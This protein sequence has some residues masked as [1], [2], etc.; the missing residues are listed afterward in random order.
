M[1]L[2]PGVVSVTIE[3]SPYAIVSVG[4]QT[5]RTQTASRGGTNPVWNETFQFNICNENDLLVELKDSEVGRDPNLGSASIN[6]MRV[7]QF[8]QDRQQVPV[9]SQR[10]MEQY[11]LISVSLSFQPD[12]YGSQQPMYGGGMQQP[13]YGGGMQQPMY[14]GGMQQ[15]MYGGG[16]GGMGMGMQGGIGMQQQVMVAE[17]FGGLPRHHHHHHH[18]RGDVEVVVIEREQYY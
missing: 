10:N 15:P 5:Y 14:G 11:G 7:R 3:Q 8:G 4:A 18:H 1:A 6:L 2:C 17:E 12:M 9:M 16:M 13:V